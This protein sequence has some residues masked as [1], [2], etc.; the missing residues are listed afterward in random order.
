MCFDHQ[1]LIVLYLEEGQGQQGAKSSLGNIDSCCSAQ[2]RAGFAIQGGTCGECS[3]SVI[4]ILTQ[5]C[6]SPNA[7]KI[8]LGVRQPVQAAPTPVTCF[9]VPWLCSVLGSCLLGRLCFPCS[10]GSSD[11]LPWWY[12]SQCC[13]DLV[14]PG[15]PLNYR[16]LIVSPKRRK[17]PKLLKIIITCISFSF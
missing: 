15:A 9:S 7:S 1:N 13:R 14:L 8:K 4:S 16:E 5:F 11:F 6:Q 17:K 10:R 2:P 12:S 3:P